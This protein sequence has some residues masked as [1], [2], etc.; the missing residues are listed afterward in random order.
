MCLGF[1][2]TP[3]K[4]RISNCQAHRSTR[5]V[6]FNHSNLLLV[7]FISSYNTDTR[8]ISIKQANMK[9]KSLALEE[10]SPATLGPPG[11]VTTVRHVKTRDGDEACHWFSPCFLTT[12]NSTCLYLWHLINTCSR[13]GFQFRFIDVCST[14]LS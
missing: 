11:L 4:V 2:G 8:I 12:Y 1:A 6:I 14:V 3:E 10:E 7:R 13:R 5:G 9:G